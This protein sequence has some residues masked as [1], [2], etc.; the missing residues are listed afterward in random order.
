MLKKEKHHDN[1]GARGVDD[2]KSWILMNGGH[3]S[4]KVS[5]RICVVKPLEKQS[6]SMSSENGSD[7]KL[8]SLP[9]EA[10][11]RPRG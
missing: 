11:C 5:S 9:E 8:P 10:N 6:T 3:R 7:M 2:W 1:Y 4:W